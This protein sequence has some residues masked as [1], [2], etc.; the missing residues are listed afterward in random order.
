MEGGGN[1][2]H[3][4]IPLSVAKIPVSST[5]SQEISS[6]ASNYTKE[7]IHTERSVSPRKGAPPTAPIR[8]N[9]KPR[10]GV[11]N[12]TTFNETDSSSEDSNSKVNDQLNSSSI[13]P[14]NSNQSLIETTTQK[15]ETL[16]NSTIK[17]VSSKT[18]VSE[19]PQKMS[20]EKVKKHKLKPTVTIG[21]SNVDEPIPASPTKNPPLGMPR[22]I[23]Y[24][25]PVMI[26]I[27]ALPLLG[28]ATYVLYRRGRDCWDK[29]HYRRMD[30]LIDGM[31]NE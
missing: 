3:A 19:T 18:S 25:V 6:S 8:I 1:F 28:V 27:F 14:S 12:E 23:D 24:I 20:T 21:G 7:G 11:G 22:K 16:S 4:T 29:R 13:L 30:F 10:K 5:I 9:I 26:T 17:N 2:T 15:L 31:Y